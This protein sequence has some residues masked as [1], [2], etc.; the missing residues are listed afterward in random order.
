MS[1]RSGT[2]LARPDE[3][4]PGTRGYFARRR[5][6]EC[7]LERTTCG[8]ISKWGLLRATPGDPGLL[9]QPILVNPGCPNMLVA[10]KCS[11]THKGNLCPFGIEVLRKCEAPW[12]LPETAKPRTIATTAP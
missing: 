6:R 7:G 2:G 3:R 1:G 11:V 8:A 9:A 4:L 12:A 5:Y 10:S